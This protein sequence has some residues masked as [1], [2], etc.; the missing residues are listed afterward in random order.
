MIDAV[1]IVGYGRLGQALHHL[2]I[3][4]GVKVRRIYSQSQ[5]GEGF[6]T[7]N[8]WLSDEDLA[9]LVFL[10][11]PDDQID[12]QLSQRSAS[13]SLFIQCSGNCER[14]ESNSFSTSVWYPLQSFSLGR[15]PEWDSIP[16]FIESHSS[17]LVNWS[18]DLG[19]NVQSIDGKQR[20][21][22]H[23]AAVWANNFGQTVIGMAAEIC[24]SHEID[25]DL[26]KPLLDET[27]SKAL[28]L[29]AVQAQ[30]GPARR[31]DQKT[32]Q[33]HLELMNADRPLQ[34]L[35]RQLSQFISERYGKA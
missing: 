7:R 22:L 32:L 3:S 9:P 10:A 33:D 27:L 28:A 19:L 4:K 21:A 35:Y 17:D 31:G 6:A 14:F 11:I 24:R 20:R 25:P 30:T 26:L 2:F 8:S 18:R 15:I 12:P 23:L 16:I 29:P 5:T 34:E 13:S 1:D